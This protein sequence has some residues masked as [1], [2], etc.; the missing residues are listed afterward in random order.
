MSD[1]HTFEA[2]VQRWIDAYVA[3]EVRLGRSLTKAVSV[4]VPGGIKFHFLMT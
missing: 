3:L 2:D 1:L 4:S